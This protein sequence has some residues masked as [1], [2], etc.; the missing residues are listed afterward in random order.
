[1]PLAFGIV[2]PLAGRLADHV[3]A[4]PLTVSG[5]AL[6]D[7]GPGPPGGPPA[8]DRLVAPPAGRDRGG[9]GPLHLAQQRL[10]H[11]CRPG[12]AGG[13]GLGGPQHVAGHGD[14]ARAGGDGHHLRGG[15]AASG[16]MERRPARLH[17]HRVRA[18]GDRGGG[19][20]GLGP[21]GERHAGR[22]RRCRRSNRRRHDVGTNRPD[23]SS[24]DGP[25]NH[26]AGVSARCRR[27]GWALRAV[28]SSRRSFS[29]NPLRRPWRWDRDMRR[30][31]TPGVAD[32]RR[33]QPW[34][35]QGSLGRWRSRCGRP[36]SASPLMS[37][38]RRRKSATSSGTSGA[39]GA[40]HRRPRPGSVR[41]VRRSCIESEKLMP[42]LHASQVCAEMRPSP[43]PIANGPNGG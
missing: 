41:I 37:E 7:P 11:G 17:R 36:R 33:R 12:P 8:V 42:T 23:R 29:E 38:G 39:S 31:R 18:G 3:G 5:M 27:R 9:H 14:G 15:G 2:A 16:G 24:G 43:R 10:H 19:G 30:S 25:D 4:R 40:M 13:N 34:R 28:R 32:T 21:A 6:V 22:T 26:A 20:R 35:P 1:M